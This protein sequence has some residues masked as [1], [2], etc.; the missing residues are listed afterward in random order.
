MP[1]FTPYL[2]AGIEDV[3]REMPG[4]VA[5]IRDWYKYYK[6]V[7]GKPENEYAFGGAA[8]DKVG[9]GNDM[10]VA[11][12]CGELLGAYR[13]LH[14]LLFE[15]WSH[16]AGVFLPRQAYAEKVIAECHASWKALKAGKVDNHGASLE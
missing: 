8:K 4:T 7:D 5:G 11:C 6:T 16:T 14:E 9:G 12:V 13:I 15:H 10:L 1:P 3:E 2:T